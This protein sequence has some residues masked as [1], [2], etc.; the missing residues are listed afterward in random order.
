MFILVNYLL[1]KK[2]MIDRKYSIGGLFSG[3]GGIEKA[4]EQA[5]YKVKWAIENDKNCN[6]VY[7]TNFPNHNLIEKDVLDH[8]NY[9]TSLDKVD[10][11]TAGFPCQAF[12]IA[13]YQ[14]GFKDEPLCKI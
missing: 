11:L 8:K 3:I 4:F 2:S 10:V 13:G 5:N 12:S 7:K 1:S 9:I 14:K 6:L